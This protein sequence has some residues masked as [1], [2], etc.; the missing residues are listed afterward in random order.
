MAIRLACST[1]T[2]RILPLREALGEIRAAGLT[3]IDLVTIPGFCPHFDP[4]RAREQDWQQL[5]SMLAEHG[6]QVTGVTAVPGDF[7]QPGVDPQVILRRADAYLRLAS[8]LGVPALNV[9]C[10][11][12]VADRNGFREHAVRQAQG[13]KKIAQRAEARGLRLNVEAPH[14]NGLCRSL[15][16]AEFLLNE[17]GEDNVDILLD[18]SHLVAARVKPEEAVWR[19]RE[20]IGYVHLRDARGQNVFLTP[21]EGEVNFARFFQA[22]E[23]VDYGGW[24]A[25]ELEIRSDSVEERRGALRRALDYL[26]EQ[27]EVASGVDFTR[28]AG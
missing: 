11:L 27:T 12:P 19:F 28:L 4:L 8:E 25:I 5:H 15:D 14:R 23:E 13:L 6:L 24:C 1:S 3:A 21:G 2:F 22:L 18:T 26:L 16:E 9:H 7:N 20:R 10:G 17:I